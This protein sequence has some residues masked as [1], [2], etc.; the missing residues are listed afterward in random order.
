LIVTGLAHVDSAEVDPAGGGGAAIDDGVDG[1]SVGKCVCQ[2]ADPASAFRS[3]SAPGTSADADVDDHNP[4]GT[5]LPESWYQPVRCVN[6]RD[7]PQ[8]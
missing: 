5:N 8:S 2:C 3:S 1:D 4:T 7:G 6:D